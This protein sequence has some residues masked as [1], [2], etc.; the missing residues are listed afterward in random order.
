MFFFLSKTLVFLISP[1]NWL[2]MVLGYGLLL[3]KSP[4]RRRRALGWAL[5]LGLLFSNKALMNEALLWWEHAPVPFASVPA[6][7]YPVAVVLT[8]ATRTAKSPKD[9][10]YYDRGVD[11]ILYAIR[12]YQEGKVKKI[13]ISGAEMELKFGVPLRDA[14]QRS[15]SETVLMA[16]VPQGD[17][18][19]ESNSVNTHE[20]AQFSAKLLRQQFAG[21]PVL[22]VTSAFHLRRALACFRHEGLVAEGFGADYYSEDRSFKPSLWLAPSTETLKNW[23]VLCKEWVGYATYWGMGYL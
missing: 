3:A 14:T 1:F 13:L 18:I 12:L 17:I 16:G 11:R 15:M 9:R 22:V 5:A 10:L 19:I 21:Q 2:L 8:G 6:G 4:Q 23:D 20:N 7:K